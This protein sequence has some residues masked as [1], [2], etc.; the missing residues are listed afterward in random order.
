MLG[1]YLETKFEIYVFWSV[2]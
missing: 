1:I 2:F